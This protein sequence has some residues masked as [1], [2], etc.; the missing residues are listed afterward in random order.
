MGHEDYINYYDKQR[1]L[2]RE[3]FAE[4]GQKS[5]L[6]LTVGQLLLENGASADRVVRDMKRVAAFMGISEEKFHLHIMY[7]TLMLNISDEHQSHT[8]FRKC[9]KHGVDLRIISAVSRLTWRALR[10][11]YTLDE[12][13]QTLKII[14]ERPR[15]YNHFM[16]ALVSGIGCSG[17]CVLFGCDINA[18]IYTLLSAMLG[19]FVQM[20]CSH[21]GFNEYVGIAFAAFTATVAA[22]FAH[23]LPTTTPWH[24]IIAC[25]IFLVPG[26]PIINGLTD[27]LN[28]F[29]FSGMAQ[30]LRTSLIVGG[31]TFGIVFAIGMFPVFDFTNLRMLPESD[32]LVFA[33]AAAISA[34]GFSALFNLPPRLLFAVGIGGAV[35]VCT[36]NLLTF[37]FGLS[38]EIGTLAGATIVSILAIRATHRLHTPMQVLIVPAVIPLVPGVLIYRFLFAF[39]HIRALSLE[40]CL[41]ALQ[42]GVDALLIIFG[43]AVGAAMPNIFAARAFERKNRAEQERLLNEA[44]KSDIAD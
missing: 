29:L 8:S 22:Y 19:K 6:L 17:A 32:F 4:I 43:I 31:M 24:P 27:M 34:I 10:E 18:A 16:T 15:Y 3:A 20:R 14:A 33:M 25:S 21:W 39:I 28:T 40:E 30:F 35:S 41:A 2:L 38:P 11:H 26:I 37:E 9:N 7:T 36:R 1:E 5:E 23:Y 44:Y 42:S 13:K 12:F